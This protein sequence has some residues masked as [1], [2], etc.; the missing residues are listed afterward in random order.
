MTPTGAWG[1]V[2]AAG[3]GERFGEAKQFLRLGE[4]TLVERSVASLAAV[5]DGV[6]AVAPLGTSP[7]AGA[8]VTVVGG[9]VRAES[10]RAGLAAVP[11]AAGIIVIHDAA[12]PLATPDLM[13]RVIA[14]VVSGADAAVPVLPVTE[15]LGRVEDGVLRDIVPKSNVALVQMPHAF[16]AEV[17]RTAHADDPDVS[18]EATLMDRLGMKVATVPGEAANVHVTTPDDLRLVAIIVGELPD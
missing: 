1:I 13:G 7:V 16:R 2:L 15:T 5:C 3:R 18:D 4:D 9:A 17:L 8:T 14:A 10:V 12:H 11:A 6:V